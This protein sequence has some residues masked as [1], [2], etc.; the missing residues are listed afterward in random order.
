MRVILL[1]PIRF[2]GSRLARYLQVFKIIP[3][4]KLQTPNSK[5]KLGVSNLEEQPCAAPCFFSEIGA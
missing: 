3:D 2:H 5:L 4:S 1:L